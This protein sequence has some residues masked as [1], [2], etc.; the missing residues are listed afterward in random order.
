MLRRPLQEAKARLSGPERP[1]LFTQWV[2][3]V[4]DWAA[5]DGRQSKIV[6]QLALRAVRNPLQS[7]ASFASIVHLLNRRRARG[8]LQRYHASAEDR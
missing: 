3:P 1:D 8:F 5:V 4:V 7:E 2:K 6:L